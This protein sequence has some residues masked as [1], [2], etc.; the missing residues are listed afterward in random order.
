MSKM[1]FGAP[2]FLRIAI[3]VIMLVTAS[4]SASAQAD[5]A[6]AVN[7]VEASYNPVLGGY[8]VTAYLTV[9]G[10][11]GLPATGLSAEQF[12]VSQDGSTI[13][14]FTI[15]PA[16]VGISIV[17]AIDTSG[18]MASSGKIEAVRQAAGSFIE[19]LDDRDR[20][21]LMSFNEAP[22]I[23]IRLTQDR[24]AVRNFVELLQPVQGASTCLWDS[25]YEA[26]ELSAAEPTG[27]RAV[28]LLTDGIDELASGGTCSTKTL[29]D[30]VALASDPA[31]SVPVYTVGIGNRVNS[32]ELGRLSDLTGGR[33]VLAADADAVGEVFNALGLQLRS[34]Y[35]L[36]YRTEQPS[37]E[38]TLFVQVEYSGGQDQ[39][40]RKFV[41]PEL[42]G[43]AMF[44]GI[45]ADQTITTDLAYELEVSGEQTP[46]LVEIYLDNA[47]TDSLRQPPYQG[48]IAVAD[49]EEGLHTLRT[50]VYGP[51]NEVLAATKIAFT[52]QAPLPEPT[53]EPLRASIA[54]ID[55]T[56]GQQ[57]REAATFAAEV[58]NPRDVATVS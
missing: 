37:G 53:P 17:L 11:A 49:L 38:H 29:E 54:L 8:D 55:V 51:G 19:G 18:S 3:I 20:I 44:S 24:S 50:V 12:G 21:G 58:D 41:A 32:Q 1:P 15:E 4:T 42:R 35:A 5:I 14:A 7:S 40:T 10:T 31:F 57:I 47:L 56:Q 16:N 45:D 2:W 22:R 39:D 9:L 30:A 27:R 13:E 46:E 43:Q 25:A 52:Y 34:G 48:S 33:S 36:R 28:V 23:E 6:I 26:V